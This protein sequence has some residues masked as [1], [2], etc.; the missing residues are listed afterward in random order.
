M[1]RLSEHFRIRRRYMRSVNLERDMERADSLDGYVPTPRALESLDRVTA[2]VMTPNVTRAWTFTGVYGT[3]KSAF[4]NLLTGVCAPKSSAVREK[5]VSLLDEE[6]ATDLVTRVNEEFPSEGLVR[7][8]V[9]GRREPVSHTV[10]RA[11]GRGAERFWQH[12]PGRR[13]AAVKEIFALRELLEEGSDVPDRDL[14]QLAAELADAA[15]TGLLLIIDELGKLLEH[16]AH[17]G[18]ARDVF[19]LQELA[20][21]RA[22]PGDAPVLTVGILHQAFSQYGQLLS[23]SEAAEWEKIQGRFED[24]PF[25]EPAE[26]MLRLMGAAIEATPPV[27]IAGAIEDDATSWHERFERS[28]AEPYISDVLSSDRNKAVYPLHPV[29]ALVLPSLCARYGQNDRSLFTFLA[30]GEPYS[31]ARFLDENGITENSRPVLRLPHVYDY[32]ID[33]ARVASMSGVQLNRWAE[34]H[35]VVEEARGLQADELD[36]LKAVGTLNLVASSGPLRASRG[37]VLSALMRDPADDDEEAHWSEVLDRLVRKRVVTYRQQVDEFRIWQGSD[38][39]IENAVHQRL[40]TERRPVGEILGDVAPLSPVV[41]QRHSYQTG[42]LR[43]F[44]RHYVDRQDRL[45]RVRRSREGS[46]GVVV[47]W[48]GAEP[49][50]SVPKTT[51]DQRPLALVCARELQVLTVAAREF[52]ALTA[53]EREEPALQSD[54]VA[55]REVRERLALARE[56][57]DSALRDAFDPRETRMQ[58]F[59]GEKRTGVRFNAGLSDLC[60][61]AYAKGPVLWNEIINRRELTSQGARAQRELL[62]ALVTHPEKE[63]LGIEGTG[64]EFSIYDSLLRNTGIHQEDDGEWVIGPPEDPGVTDLWEAIEGFCLSATDEPRQVSRLYEL[65]EA[66]PYGAKTGV[67]PIFLAA[68]LIYH[69]E[70]VSV[71]QEGSFIPVLTPALFEL[72]VKRPELFAVKHFELVG[73]RWE[74]FKELES[75]LRAGGAKRV[76]GARNTTLLTVVRP[77][78]QFVLGLPE[79]TKSAQDISE[80]AAGVREALLSV[81]EPDRLVFD[82]LPQACGQPAFVDDEDIDR[83][84]VEDFRRALLSALRE[85]QTHYGRLLEQ[86]RELIHN[87]FG[88]HSDVKRLREDLRVRAQY[89]VGKVI[90]P[91]LRSFTLAAVNEESSDQEWLES[92]VMIIADRPA[93]SWSE[94]DRLAFEL[95]LG[96]MA[97]RFRNLEALQ[98]EAVRQGREGFDARRIT[99]TEPGGREV[100]RLVWVDA[101]ERPRIEDKA[102]ELVAA[103]RQ[104]PQEHRQHAVLVSVLERILGVQ[105]ESE[106]GP[107]IETEQEEVRKHG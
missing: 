18:G 13:P 69:S 92:I 79:V 96:E 58:W 98:K 75:V 43:F 60:D 21:L 105:S 30:S 55:R 73:V 28:V 29:A 10:V 47:Y 9:V 62:T 37:L 77:L 19:L 90:E 71:Y 7:A 56:V 46:D 104:V 17:S 25:A 40:K 35:A 41:A 52:A 42:N 14:A 8:V 88:V 67:I 61:Q 3:G 16:A 34:I 2:A 63:K 91:R 38:F 64:A 54:G 93:E 82:A 76:E 99:V 24:I 97:R 106:A 32:F 36:A 103:I 48:V 53:V 26:Q 84:R 50:K 85:L 94:D 80:E 57:L 95:N 39:H 59:G 23:K 101:E 51:T 74:L 107:T 31:L 83:R 22:E 44:E 1:S 68:V 70:D 86:C 81:R 78:I 65:L 27:G 4:A 12:R 72:L 5:A 20:E 87:A 33:I 6:G 66:P 89:L 15:G 45:E 100:H 102:E 49:P 11:L